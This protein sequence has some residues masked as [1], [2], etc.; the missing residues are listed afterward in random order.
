MLPTAGITL[1]ST[2]VLLVPVTV[3]ENC[4]VW[5]AYRIAVVGFTDIPTD[6][7]G[8]GGVNGAPMISISLTNAHETCAKLHRTYRA[9]RLIATS[10]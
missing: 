2:A 1:H 7:G 4:W 6:P 5:P 8:G 3:A 9:F 10:V